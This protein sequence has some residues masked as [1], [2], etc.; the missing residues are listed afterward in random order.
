MNPRTIRFI[1]PA[2]ALAALALLC[3]CQATARSPA[4]MRAQASA[5]RLVRANQAAGAARPCLV[6]AL[7]QV[8]PFTL[9][10][11]SRP[12]QVRELGGRTELFAQD[13]SVTLYLVDL[14]DGGARSSSAAIYA[15][16]PAIADQVATAARSCGFV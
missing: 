8:R 15:G 1:A 7:D 10:P 16:T 6:A 11:G 14:A 12:V 9:E 13:E 5:P 3:G 4:D 2:A